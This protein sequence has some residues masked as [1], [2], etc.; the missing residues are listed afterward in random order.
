MDTVEFDEAGIDLLFDGFS[1][2]VLLGDELACLVALDLLLETGDALGFGFIDRGDF[3][4]LRFKLLDGGGLGLARLGLESR[5]LAMLTSLC[6][7][8]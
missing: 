2:G 3:R 1:K 7:R 4:E 8:R 6:L 5:F